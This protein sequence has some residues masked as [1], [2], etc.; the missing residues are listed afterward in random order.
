VLPADGD[1]RVARAPSFPRRLAKRLALRIP[2]IRRLVEE[3]HQLAER[4]RELE[5]ARR[6]RSARPY[7]ICE[8]V[9]PE[10]YGDPEWLA[11][12]RDLER[13]SIDKHC[14]Q[15][16]TGQIYRKG[17]EWTQCIYGLRKLGMIREDKVALGVGAGREC[18]IYYLA[19]HV[20]RVVASDLYG[21]EAWTRVGGLEADLRLLEQSK[22]ACPPTVD[23]S[24]IVFET[25][26]GTRLTYEDASF[27]F[28]WSLSSIEH[29][30][31]HEAAAA[32]MREMARVTRP[33][34]VVAVATELLML[35][36]YQHDE[37]FTRADVD[38]YIVRASA[39]LELVEDIDFDTLSV[40]YLVDSVPLPHGVDRLRRHV[41]LNDGH[42][43]WT[44]VMMFFRKRR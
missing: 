15:H 13:Y 27:D 24:K 18:V 30:G 1:D 41:V 36:E 11:V 19:D 7:G 20:A 9:N 6:P 23:F 42:V 25:Q 26:D 21:A 16:C 35:E 39:D 2:A 31:G 37:Y 10:R 44:S 38:R 29:F 5:T 3:R 14:F 22:A 32:A 12:H 33:G 4:V 40:P 34:G 8:V 43:Q 17:W 28:C